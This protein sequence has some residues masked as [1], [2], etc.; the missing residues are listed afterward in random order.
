MH[1]DYTC[2]LL[3]V[4]YQ[5]FLRQ[6][7]KSSKLEAFIVNVTGFILQKFSL[8]SKLC[9][10]KQYLFN[11]RGKEYITWVYLLK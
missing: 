11:I 2:V 3:G 5:F 9:F 4:H 8:S 6:Y 7:Y 10:A 1:S